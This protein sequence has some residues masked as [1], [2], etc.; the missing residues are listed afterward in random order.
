MINMPQKI[1]VFTDGSSRGNPGPG[2]WGAII[3]YPVNNDANTKVFEL[4]GREENTTNN[5]M[6]MMAAREAL[7]FIESRKLEGGIEIHTDSAYLLQG[8]TGWMYG[9]EKN[10]WKTKDGG[11]VLNQDIWRELG[12]LVFRLKQKHEIEWI[13]VSGHSGLR[14]NER[15]DE[16]CTNAADKTQQILFVGSL[17]DYEQLIGGTVFDV[18]PD[19]EKLK[20]KTRKSSSKLAYSYVSMIGGLVEIHKTWPEC[21][22]RVKGKR[23]AKYQK[24]FSREEES[25]LTEEWTTSMLKQN[26]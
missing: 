23:G 21:E 14:G 20:V 13:K 1:V 24:V 15:V 18:D 5:R 7:S 19:T 8:I 2:G 4:G 3:V 10:G 11:D 6:E 16:I 26:H 9:W 22:K 17:T 12:A 25:S